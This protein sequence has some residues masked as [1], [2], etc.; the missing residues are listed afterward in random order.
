MEDRLKHQPTAHEPQRA[1]ANRVCNPP[2]QGPNPERNL[3]ING[4]KSGSR[5]VGTVGTKNAML[6]IAGDAHPLTPI[7]VDFRSLRLAERAEFL[8]TISPP[9]KNGEQTQVY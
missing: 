2:P 8:M 7:R 5:S 6:Y 4:G 1:H 3:L 9:D